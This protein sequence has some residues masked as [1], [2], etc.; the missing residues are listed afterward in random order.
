MLAQKHTHPVRKTRRIHF[1]SV[2][3]RHSWKS[4]VQTAERRGKRYTS[5]SIN[6]VATA[7]LTCIKMQTLFYLLRERCS[8]QS[9]GGHGPTLF[10]IYEESKTKRTRHEREVSARVRNG[11]L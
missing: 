1:I 4:L 3:D 6:R 11:R 5:I 2:M 7:Y 9:S 8:V 10:A